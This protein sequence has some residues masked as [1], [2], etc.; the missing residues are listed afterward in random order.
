MKLSHKPL[1]SPRAEDMAIALA[2]MVLAIVA[3]CFSMTSLGW[4]LADA[5]V[6]LLSVG[7][8]AIAYCFGVDLTLPARRSQGLAIVFLVVLTL[9]ALMAVL[10]LWISW[11][12]P[13]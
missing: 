5:S 3:A 13:Y 10:L 1:R 6:I 7:A 9:I 12:N 4:D 2:M 8:V 11:H